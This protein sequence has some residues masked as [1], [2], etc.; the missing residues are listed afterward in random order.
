VYPHAGDWTEG[1][2]HAEAEALNVPSAPFQ[3]AVSGRAGPLPAE[4]SFYAVEPADLIVS[5]FKQ[6]QDYN[7]H[8]LVAPES[9][10][11]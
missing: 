9:T 2:V 10:V 3:V 7:I 11:E 4:A 8:S 5:A 6:A 1:D